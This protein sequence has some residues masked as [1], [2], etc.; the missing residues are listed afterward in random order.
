MNKSFI[1]YFCISLVLILFFIFIGVRA[2]S[3]VIPIASHQDAIYPDCVN[4]LPNRVTL[5]LFHES[6]SRGNQAAC[7][8]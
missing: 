3:G 2:N 5:P 4:C 1:V 8:C 7:P 6:H